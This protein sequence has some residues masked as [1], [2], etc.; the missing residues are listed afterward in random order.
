MT[1]DQLGDPST[2]CGDFFVVEG[3]SISLVS[4][5]LQADFQGMVA[6]DSSNLSSEV[7]CDSET[8]PGV[9]LRAGNLMT[10]RPEL[11]GYKNSALSRKVSA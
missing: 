3:D 2:P 7:Y 11:L 1:S 6:R 5:L 9:S 8:L 10:G 4:R